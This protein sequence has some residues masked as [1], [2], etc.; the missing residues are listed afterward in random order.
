MN[1][2]VALVTGANRGIGKEICRQLA[3]KGYRVVLTARDQEKGMLA[4]RELQSAGDIHF[5]QLDLNRVES[6]A[7]FREKL[8]GEFGRLDVLVNNA[9]VLLDGNT[10]AV[11]T[12][13]D[14]VR[15]SLE[16]NLLGPL[17]LCRAFIPVMLKQDY[18]R[19]INLSSGM[20]A[21]N[22]MGSGY[23]GYRISK[24]ALNA[25]T[26]LLAVELRGK[27]VHIN[28]MCPGWVKTDMGGPGAS[29]TV[30]Q[31]A[32][33]AVWLAG[34]PAGGPSGKFFRDRK[35]IRW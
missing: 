29:R 9:A 6:F 17:A 10:A 22:E 2:Q 32:D 21:F 31:G 35:E 5:M 19:I 33:T 11:N 20:G 16:T 18:G 23:A 26:N 4:V 27:N 7:D 14:V 1:M 30:E 13:I 28:A 8:I 12:D 25:M 24:T 15:R 3:L 34:Q